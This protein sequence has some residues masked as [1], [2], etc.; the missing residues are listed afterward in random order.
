MAFFAPEKHPPKSTDFR[1]DSNSWDFN[2]VDTPASHIDLFSTAAAAAGVDVPRDRKIDGVDL[3]P[4]ARGE[5]EGDAHDALFWRSGGLSV[6]MSRGWKLQVDLRQAKR[7][8]FDLTADP[9]EQRNQLSSQPDVARDL[10]A[11]LDSINAELGPRAFP[12]LVEGV[13]AIDR[14]IA[15]PVLPGEE[16][17]YWPN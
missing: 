6:A 13:I 3:L 1:W 2:S 9:T 11:K 12:V 7:W 5:R 15:D 4:F 8:L 17:A 16:F 10:Q 14:T